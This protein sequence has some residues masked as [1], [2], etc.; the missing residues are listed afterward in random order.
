[1]LVTCRVEE[2]NAPFRA[3]SLRQFGGRRSGIGQADHP[4]PRQQGSDGEQLLDLLVAI[5]CFR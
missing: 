1:M 5:F 2:L 3:L 4:E